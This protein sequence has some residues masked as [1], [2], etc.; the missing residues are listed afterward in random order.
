M[1]GGV[2]RPSSVKIPSGSQSPDNTPT[3]PISGGASGRIVK[4]MNADP[5]TKVETNLGP[6][7]GTWGSTPFNQGGGA[8]G[9]IYK[10][11]PL[12]PRTRE[13]LFEQSE[14][15]YKKALNNPKVDKSKLKEPTR[16]ETGKMEAKIEVHPGHGTHSNGEPGG[17]YIKV[18][19]KRI[20]GGRT[21]KT[22]GHEEL[23]KRVGAHGAFGPKE[24][25][26]GQK[27]RKFESQGIVPENEWR[28]P[29]LTD[30][31]PPSPTTAGRLMN[32]LTKNP[33]EVVHALNNKT[34]DTSYQKI[35]D[36][37]FQ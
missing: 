26:D 16:V 8:V 29:T 14:A 10:D 36:K 32:A 30:S 13:N 12:S 24:T 31:P 17:S 27:L 9:H 19:S 18:E 4:I 33:V 28:K 3:S 25:Y 1:L 34:P 21:D 11:V 20:V 6:K 37:F 23:E 35:A 2:N 15:K 5:N 7:S 22:P